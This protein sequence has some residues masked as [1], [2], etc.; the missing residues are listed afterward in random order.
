ML[1]S[2]MV[3]RELM[4][5]GLLEGDEV[6]ALCPERPLVLLDVARAPILLCTAHATE[7][8][9]QLQVDLEEGQRFPRGAPG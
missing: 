7:V 8:V 6:C 3:W 2:E 4:G 1:L 5:V 9:R